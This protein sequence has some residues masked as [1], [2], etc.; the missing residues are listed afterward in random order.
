MRYRIA[1]INRAALLNTVGVNHG[2]KWLY[3][4][5]HR[6]K[7]LYMRLF[8]YAHGHPDEDKSSLLDY[9]DP[10]MERDEINKIRIYSI[11]EMWYFINRIKA[12]LMMS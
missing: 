1:T 8:F 2:R 11:T 3:E 7:E 4:E 12:L 9:T 6:R 10:C 5:Y